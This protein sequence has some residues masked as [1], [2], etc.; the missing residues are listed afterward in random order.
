MFRG[1]CGH[2]LKQAEYIPEKRNAK[3]QE[4]I[5]AEEK[6]EMK[7]GRIEKRG[8]SFEFGGAMKMQKKDLEIGRA[9]CRERVSTPV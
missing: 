1:T 4:S 2:E 9:S 6:E 5:V 7:S 8:R 3:S